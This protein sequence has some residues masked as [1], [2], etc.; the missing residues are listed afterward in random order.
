MSQCN[1]KVEFEGQAKDNVAKAK[2]AIIAAKGR[3]EGNDENGDFQVHTILGNI[4]GLYKIE[5]SILV[6]TVTHKPF[7]LSCK[8]LE[9]KLREYVAP[10]IA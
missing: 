6:L 7:L 4:S 5:D 2:A 9:K 1:I 3:F 10:Q 8:T